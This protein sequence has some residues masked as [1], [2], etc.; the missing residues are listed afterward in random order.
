MNSAELDA[1]GAANETKIAA[2][3]GASPELL[4]ALAGKQ[5]GRESEVA[6]RT[7]RVVSASLGVMQEQKAGRKRNRSLAL[8]FVLLVI[9]ALGPLLWRVADDL[10]GGEHIGDLPTQITLLVCILCP[11]LV[12][13]ALVAGWSRRKP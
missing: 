3:N 12:A 9:F 8:A 7:R 10:L 6:Y 11:S 5:A 1:Y 4:S 2:G 13:A